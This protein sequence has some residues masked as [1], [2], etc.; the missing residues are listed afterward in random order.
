VEH[1]KEVL[2][3]VKTLFVHIMEGNEHQNYWVTNIPKNAFVLA[4]TD[5]KNK[6]IIPVWNNMRV[7]NDS[8]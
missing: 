2:I 5:E 8:V 1:V 3:N 6:E 7:N 4:F